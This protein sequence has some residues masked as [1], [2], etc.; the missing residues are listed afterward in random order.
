MGEIRMA[1]IQKHETEKLKDWIIRFIKDHNEIIY[2]NLSGY[3]DYEFVDD[4][5]SQIFREFG[6][7]V[8]G[9]S[10]SISFETVSYDTNDKMLNTCCTIYIFSDIEKVFGLK[11][12][13]V[14]VKYDNEAL[15]NS[16]VYL[17]DSNTDINEFINFLI[18]VE[19]SGIENI[20]EKLNEL[21]SNI[22]T[23]IN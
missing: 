8:Q 2:P 3:N 16:K 21:K 9:I 18:K 13:I 1:V 4:M 19:V 6:D 5:F 7:Y 11:G 15:W 10:N 23:H 12:Y 22:L 17:K 20:I 14:H